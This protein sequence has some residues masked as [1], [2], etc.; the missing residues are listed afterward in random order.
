MQYLGLALTC[1]HCL[2]EMPAVAF[3]NANALFGYRLCQSCHSELKDRIQFVT[4]QA[5]ALYLALR[6]NN[7]SAELEKFDGFKKVDIAVDEVYIH[8]EVD[9]KHHYTAEQALKDLKRTT[10]S[11]QNEY[12][13]IRIPNELIDHELKQT[14]DHLAAI[15]Q[16]RQRKA[17]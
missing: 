10:Y 8:I 11:L 14:C 2:S 5:F 7:I 1:S 6:Q 15:V 4:K 16:F 9:G 17:G 13:T 3:F 12:I